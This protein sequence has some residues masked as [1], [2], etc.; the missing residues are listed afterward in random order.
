MTNMKEKELRAGV[1][2]LAGIW[3]SDIFLQEDL[4][5]IQT[6]CITKGF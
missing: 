5:V 6:K 1:L 4:I 2:R 3:M